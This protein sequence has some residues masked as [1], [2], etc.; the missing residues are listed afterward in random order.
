MTTNDLILVTGATGKTG[1]RLAARLATVGRR[2]RMGSRRAKPAFD[3][4]DRST[5][6]AA[7]AGASAAYV[8]FQPDIAVPGALETVRA[9]FAEAMAAGCTR[10]VLLSGRGEPEAEAAEAVLQASGA[11]WTVLRASWFDQNFDE[12]F[13]LEPI[14]AGE[15]ALPAGTAPEPF[16]DV[17]DIAE[18]AAK[19]LTEPGHVGKLY[20]LTGPRAL[21]FAEATAEIAKATGRPVAYVPIPAE[22]YREGMAQAGVPAEVIEL[23]LHLFTT[24]LDGR[25]TPVRDGVRQVL[26]REPTDF[27]AYVARVAA[28]GVWSGQDAPR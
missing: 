9:F 1:R 18:V 22:A 23:T 10:L 2:V 8:C 11:D 12:S 19:V 14:L 28:S 5:W 26:A 24:V 25:N 4:E 6:G 7:L 15:L 20:E 21:T 13:F 17:E 27:A 16:V 3:W